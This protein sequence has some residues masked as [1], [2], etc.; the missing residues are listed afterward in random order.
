MTTWHYLAVFVEHG[1]E[2]TY[3]F[4]EVFRDK[5]GRVEGWT[6]SHDIAPSG[7]SIAELTGDLHHMLNDATRW[8]PV[9][10]S[11]LTAGMVLKAASQEPK[12]DK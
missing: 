1:S 7:S 6:Q 4:C 3:S 11:D 8:E 9:R 5:H 10:F 2:R 12:V